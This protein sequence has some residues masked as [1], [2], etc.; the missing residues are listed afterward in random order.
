MAT[1][2]LLDLGNVVLGVDFR[3]V[4]SAWARAAD[5]D[6]DRFYEHWSLDDAY[7]AH[8]RGELHFADYAEH[9]GTVFDVTLDEQ[10]WL[11]GWNDIWTEPFADVINL[12]P[13]VA[14]RYP[15]YCFTNTNDAHTQYWRANY[16]GAL[17]HFKH[18]FVSSEIG[19]RK[20]DVTAFQ[21][22]CEQMQQVPSDVL[23]LDDTQENVQGALEAGL[24]AICTP[25]QQA[26]V[27]EL[28]RLL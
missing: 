17:A 25:D 28:E 8:E 20:P 19:A 5:V 1:A 24:N 12:L 16:P 2:V 9:L 11:A 13:D 22:V 18:I 23:F 14:A 15:L 4:F 7:K 6:E 21:Q 26:V 10:D 27:R 3:R